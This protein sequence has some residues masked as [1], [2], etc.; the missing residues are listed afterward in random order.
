MTIAASDDAH[1]VF[2]FSPD[3]LSVNGTEPGD[4]HSTV[5][6]QVSS[7]DIDTALGTKLATIFKYSILYCI[8]HHHTMSFFPLP[9][10]SVIW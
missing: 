8:I 4:G 1:G 5:V 9:G 10:G 7:Q 2:Q 6:L 3:S